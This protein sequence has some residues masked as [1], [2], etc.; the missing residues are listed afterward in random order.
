MSY[1]RESSM[2]VPLKLQ[3]WCHCKNLSSGQIFEVRL[4]ICPTHTKSHPHAQI[5]RSESFATLLHL[6]SPMGW[7]PFLILYALDTF[8]NVAINKGRKNS[9]LK[10]HTYYIS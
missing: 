5:H 1:N 4:G 3:T 8:A 6:D 9:I 2:Y 7:I 10:E